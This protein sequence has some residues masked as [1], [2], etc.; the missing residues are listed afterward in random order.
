VAVYH[1]GKLETLKKG[2]GLT[3]RQE[4]SRGSLTYTYCLGKDVF[5]REGTY[6]VFL[7]SSDAAGNRADSVSQKL[8]VQFAIDHTGPE[9]LLTGI[10]PGAVYAQDHVMLCAQVRDNLKLDHVEVYVD[11]RLAQSVSGESLERQDGLLQR[12]FTVKDTWQRFQL[13]AEDAAGNK[14][15][16]REIVFYVAGEKREVEKVEPYDNSLPSARQ[17]KEG[18]DPEKE[19]TIRKASLGSIPGEELFREQMKGEREK[20]GKIPTLLGSAGTLF[21]LLSLAA[22]IRLKK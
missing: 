22:V 3:M 20:A 1:N 8:S 2:E 10:E 12:E 7:T 16:S 19:V 5:G 13:C 17:E 4:G 14:S 11:G 6:E 21:A 15:W 18:D 9:C